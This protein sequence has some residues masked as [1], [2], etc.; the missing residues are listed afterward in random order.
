MV[1]LSI[2]LALSKISSKSTLAGC[3][4][5]VD[6]QIWNRAD[7]NTLNQLQ[8]IFT[9][10]KTPKQVRPKKSLQLKQSSFSQILVE[11]RHVLVLSVTLY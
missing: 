10:P 8:H 6:Y 1:L 11:N 5:K 4:T 9:F 7:E 3:I 2:K